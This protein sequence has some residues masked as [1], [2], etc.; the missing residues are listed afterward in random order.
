MKDSSSILTGTEGVSYRFSQ[1]MRGQLGV[2]VHRAESLNGSSVFITCACGHRG[3]AFEGERCRCTTDI[4]ANG[5]ALPR[6]LECDICAAQVVLRAGR[7]RVDT[8]YELLPRGTIYRMILECMN[9]MNSYWPVRPALSR[10]R[11]LRSVSPSPCLCLI[12]ALNRPV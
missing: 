7:Q 9:C 12:K 1:T 2:E 11:R 5:S 3:A 8:S 6:L 10:A 4:G